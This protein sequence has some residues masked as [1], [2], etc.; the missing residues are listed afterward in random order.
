MVN[1]I[2]DF[3]EKTKKKS[4][5]LSFVSTS[6]YEIKIKIAPPLDFLKIIDAFL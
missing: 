2:F 3:I 1:E 4:L 6:G 5:P